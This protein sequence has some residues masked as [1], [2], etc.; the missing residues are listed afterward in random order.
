MLLL[1]KHDST[2]VARLGLNVYLFGPRTSLTPLLRR[3]L[4]L[5]CPDRSLPGEA[6]A[7]EKKEACILCGHALLSKA[8]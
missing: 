5:C 7:A 6:S 3:G 4:V 1:H 8:L 2:S